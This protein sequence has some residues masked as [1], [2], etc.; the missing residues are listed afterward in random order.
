MHF[1]YNF[2]YFKVRKT[3]VTFIGAALNCDSVVLKVGSILLLYSHTILM[4]L[5]HASVFG[6][7]SLLSCE[8]LS[9]LEGERVSE[10]ERVSVCEEE[11]WM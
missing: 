5:A 4:L 2:Q 11:V 1:M 3:L 8:L 10:R 9:L 7:V 6:M